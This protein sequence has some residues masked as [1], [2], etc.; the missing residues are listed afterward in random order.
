MIKNMNPHVE[1]FRGAQKILVWA[2]FPYMIAH[3]IGR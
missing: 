2:G 1:R 3:H